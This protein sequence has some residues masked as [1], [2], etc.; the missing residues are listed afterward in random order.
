MNSKTFNIVIGALVLLAILAALFFVWILFFTG[1]PA[2]TG[3]QGGSFLSLLQGTKNTSPTN[4]TDTNVPLNGVQQPA[5]GG[6]VQKIFKIADGPIV[7]ATFIQTQN[8]TT[9]IARYITADT[10]H[11]LDLVIDSPGNI[12]K[13]VSNTTIP[14]LISA[15]WAERGN[16]VVVQYFEGRTVKTLYEQFA[17]S[18]TAIPPR[19]HFFPD[20][21]QSYDVSPDG[22]SLT[23]LL[24]TAGGTNGYIASTTGTNTKRLFSLPLTQ[25]LV[26]WPAKSA[27]LV[28]SKEAAGV[29][30]IA[31]SIKT[32]DGSATPLVYANGLTAMANVDFSRVIY[33]TIA[34]P[35]TQG[36]TYSHDT[37]NGF[38]L[39]VP[40]SPAP[41]KCRWSSVATTTLYC[42]VPVD[43]RT[44]NYVDL[45]HVG[46]AVDADDI[47]VFN[48]LGGMTEIA[49]VPGSKQ[50]GT[51]T[52]IE[53][54]A[55]S[56]QD[57]YLSYVTYGDRSLW[58]VRLTQ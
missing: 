13:V 26:S 48:T 2:Q 5:M 7:S 47:G 40:A 41:E 49:T 17:S 18:T 24:K 53:N 52:P 54:I 35:A 46:V 37:L 20:D 34:D 22:M 56:P 1:S 33:Q 38:D 32:K 44:A 30:G 58:G 11:I 50:G 9:T 51:A 45:L 27:L 10:G 57:T 14:G 21:I 55:L 39:P 36:L 15:K 43:S 6:V 31:F 25:T 12:A 23:Y 4:A 16:A 3:A 8:P 29:P 42:A 19:I 28:T